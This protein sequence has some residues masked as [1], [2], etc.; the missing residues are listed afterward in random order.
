MSARLAVL[1]SVGLLC[2]ACSAV[3]EQKTFE[4]APAWYDNVPA[5][6]GVGSAKHRGIKDLTRKSAIA[7][8]RQ[9]LA[10]QLQAQVQALIDGYQQAGETG[11]QDFT[12]ELKTNTMR[13]V[14][15]QTMVG[16]KV[17]A[18]ALV[19][20]EFYAMV[21]LDPEAFANAFDKMNQLSEKQ[22]EALRTRAKEKFKDLDAQVNKLREGR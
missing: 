3:P 11:G 17:A 21:C 9:E 14:T 4:D 13:E 19:G 15:D 10:A 22:R 7:A 6:C 18:T 12:E 5:G 8:A 16:T 2:V 20:T 1:A